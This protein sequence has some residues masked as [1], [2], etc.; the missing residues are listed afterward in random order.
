M[1][2]VKNMDGLEEYPELHKKMKEE[3]KSL[4]DKCDNYAKK[5]SNLK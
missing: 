3:I 4:T 5:K 2:E 1:K